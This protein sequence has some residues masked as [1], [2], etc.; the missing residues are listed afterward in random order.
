[1]LFAATSYV[2]NVLGRKFVEPPVLDLGETLADSSPLT[3]LIFVLSPGVDPTDALRKLADER[4]MA[5]R[6]HSVALGQG[7]VGGGPAHPCNRGFLPVVTEASGLQEGAASCGPPKQR[8][9]GAHDSLP[10]VLQA[11]Q[12]CWPSIG[13]HQWVA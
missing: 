7:Q 6:L 5:G 12:S 9:E 1:M 2:A 13:C 8:D 3:P 10:N 11:P 4:G